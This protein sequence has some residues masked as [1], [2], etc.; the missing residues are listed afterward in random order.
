[1]I[2]KE[3]AERICAAP[4]NGDYG[5]FSVYMQ[6][7]TEP[8]I[9]FDVSRGSFMPAPNVDSAVIRLKIRKEPAVTVA[10]EKLFFRVVKAAFAQRRKTAV[11]SV[12]NTLGMKKQTVTD[13]FV[14]AGIEVNARAE[15]LTLE[16][17]AALANALHEGE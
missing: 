10:D 15:A 16:Q 6:F 2:Q 4:G 11:N 9:L 13:A 17:F 1:M 7:Y 14:R 8:E 12:S 3:V 5:A